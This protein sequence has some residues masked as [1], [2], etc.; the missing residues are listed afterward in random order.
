[1]CNYSD[2]HIIPFP[3]PEKQNKRKMANTEKTKPKKR[4]LKNKKRKFEIFLFF[5]NDASHAMHI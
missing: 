3:P 5:K 4:L 1:M 2:E